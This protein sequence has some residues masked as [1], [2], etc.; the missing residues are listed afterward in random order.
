MTDG[1]PSKPGKGKV[2][3]NRMK[4]LPIVGALFI[5]LAVNLLLFILNPLKSWEHYVEPTT[6]GWAWWATTD[7]LSRQQP[8]NVVVFG[9]SAVMHPLWLQE[10]A[11]RNQDVEIVVDHQSRYLESVIKKYSPTAE[12]ICFN[13]GLPGCMPSDDYMIMRA[14]FKAERKPKIAVI[15]LHPRDLMDNTFSCAASSKHFQHMARFTDAEPLLELSMPQFWRRMAY[16]LESL[17]FLKSK[18]DDIQQ[19]LTDCLRPVTDRCFGGLPRNPL[20]G[21][22]EE[23]R[24]LACYAIDIEKGV[25]IA[26]PTSPYWYVEATAD[27]RKR[28]KKSNES[29]FENQKTW[30]KMCLDI[31]KKEEIKAVIVNMPTTATVRQSMPPATRERHLRT[32][33]ELAAAYGCP[34]LDIDVE[35]RYEAQDFTDWIH[36]DASGGEKVLA[37]I[38]K[39]I[40]ETSE[41]SSCLANPD[42]KLAVSGKRT[43]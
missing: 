25:W 33:K 2:V 35:G 15:G 36:M 31:C 27:C 5:V 1:Q 16:R 28:F 23:D 6:R 8:A 7:F 32:V 14:L 40:G 12:P 20:D 18:H 22:A 21:T 37:A 26:H 3:V 24:R 34:F 42:A 29:L 17:L 43:M 30:L 41:L 10:A 11:F 13:F 4:R 9:S 38:G 39:F 19:L